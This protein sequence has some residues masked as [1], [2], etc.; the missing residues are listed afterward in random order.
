MTDLKLFVW[1]NVFWDYTPGLCFAI[2]KS[3]QEA[4]DLIC[5]LDHPTF[6]YNMDDLE[7]KKPAVYE[8]NTIQPLAYAVFG[9]G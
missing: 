5:S 6:I 4:I 3:R 7:T 1:E 2:A 9:G 8:I